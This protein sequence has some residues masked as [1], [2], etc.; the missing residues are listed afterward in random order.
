VDV[1]AWGAQG[2]RDGEFMRPRAIGVHDGEVYVVDTTGRIQVFTRDG[3]YVRQWSMPEYENGTPTCIAFAGDGRVLIPDTHYSRI[4]EYTTNGELLT[5]W[6]SYGTAPGTF[7][8]PTGLAESSNGRYFT[9]EY[10]VDAERVQR[11]SK[12]RVFEKTWGTHGT[13]PGQFNRAMAIVVA[14]DDTV[15]VSDTTNH[16]LQVFDADG[17]LIRIIGTPGTERGR[18]KFPQG[19]ALAADGSV[20]V[21]EYGA[22]RVSRFSIAGEYLGS[23]GSAGRI[24]GRFAAPR[25]VAVSADGDVFVAD[26]ENHRIQRFRLEAIV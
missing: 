12:D 9:S 20:V 23:F 4:A 26:T 1:L 19:I 25:G 17:T 13:D 16:R 2:T 6:G 11:F 18:L 21:C 15:C 7:I 8:Y 22:N 14:A 24:P 3:A 5:M 10:G